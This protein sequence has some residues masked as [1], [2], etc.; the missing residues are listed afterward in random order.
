M[1]F[2]LCKVY[3]YLDFF[4]YLSLFHSFLLEQV[5]LA[6]SLLSWKMKVCGKGKG[7]M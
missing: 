5:F 6:L 7:K 3:C 2:T 4:L 1:M